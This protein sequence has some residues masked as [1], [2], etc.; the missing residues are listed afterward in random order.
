MSCDCSVDNDGP[1]QRRVLV[2][3]LLINSLMFVGEIIVGIL[4]DSTGLIAD[5]LDM[6]ADAFVYAIGLYAVGKSNITKIS[7]AKWS[8][9]CQIALAVSV[10]VDVGRRFIFGSEPESV[11]ILWMGSIA[12][13]ANLV[14]LRLIA[15]HRRGEVHMRA[16]WIFSKNDVLANLGVIVA[17]LLVRFT[18]TRWPDLIVGTA[19]AGLVLRG[20]IQILR[21]A[22]SEKQC[23]E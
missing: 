10:I 12:L 15:A 1:V 6:L 2:A 23:A 11:L 4:A 17:G 5:S 18:G 19:I 7:A 20:G 3:L 16:S 13:V 8:G 21:D 22:A 9:V 14:C